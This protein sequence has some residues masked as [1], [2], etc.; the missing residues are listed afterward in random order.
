MFNQS[1]ACIHTHAFIPVSETIKK[2]NR[3]VHWFECYVTYSHQ[4]RT[5][6]S[7]VGETDSTCCTRAIL[8]RDF[9]SLLSDPWIQTFQSMKIHKTKTRTSHPVDVH[10]ATIKKQQQQPYVASTQQY[11]MIYHGNAAEKKRR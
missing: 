7:R 5:S 6:T 3:R 2:I 9:F 8:Q 10:T 11:A 1:Y 4:Q